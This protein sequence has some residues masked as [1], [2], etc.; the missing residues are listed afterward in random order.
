MQECTQLILWSNRTLWKSI[1]ADDVAATQQRFEAF[2]MAVTGLPQNPFELLQGDEWLIVN[3]P[4]LR[5]SKHR[6]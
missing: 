2:V 1:P 6:S 5:S 3:P 4:A